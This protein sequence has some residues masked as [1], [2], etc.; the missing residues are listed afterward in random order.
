[1]N[2]MDGIISAI[3]TQK[4]RAA[5]SSPDGEAEHTVTVSGNTPSIA[6]T[7]K[8]LYLCGKPTSLTISSLPASGL[9]EIIF[10][11]GSAAPQIILPANVLLPGGLT[12]EA[13]YLYGVSIRVCEVCGTV[14]G[15]AAVQ[16]WPVPVTEEEEE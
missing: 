2:L 10:E 13:G 1:M 16:G 12:I 9:F 3:L 14:Y 6:A 8:T 11:S 7:D 5:M 4:G 15:L